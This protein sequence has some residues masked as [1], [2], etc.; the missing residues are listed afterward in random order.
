[1]EKPKLRTPLKTVRGLGSAK[2]GTMHWWWQRVSAIAIMPLSIWFIYAVMT[3]L[4]NQDNAAEWFRAPAP[5]FILLALLL[6]G[7][8]HGQLGM[9]VIIEDY[10][11]CKFKKFSLLIINKLFFLALAVISA[12]SIFKLH[13]G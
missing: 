7:A 8:Y 4:R 9:Q 1:M 10:V 6:A 5:A 11:H 3:Q 13:L 12:L 2:D